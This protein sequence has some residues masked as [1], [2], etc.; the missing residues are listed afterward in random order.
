MTMGQGIFSPKGFLMA[1]GIVLVLLGVVGYL[2]IFSESAYPAFWLDN[3]E[4]VAHIA[5][6]VVALAALYVPG[7]N[8]ALAPYYR[9]IVLLVGVIALFFGIYGF[10]V[11]AGS[12][13]DPNTF[14]L[15]N[16]ESPADNILHLVVAAWAFLAGWKSEPSM[17]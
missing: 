5:L 12:S 1:G 17:A 7:L 4:N 8:S 16:L 13:T 2:G 9:W 10:V 11:P 3:G 14:G 6:G 15:A